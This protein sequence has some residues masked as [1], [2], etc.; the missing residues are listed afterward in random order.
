VKL[1][2]ETG[3]R[4]AGLLKARQ[5]DRPLEAGGSRDQPQLESAAGRLEQLP[6]GDRQ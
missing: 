6:Y 4:Q 5:R 2:Q 3:Q 1:G